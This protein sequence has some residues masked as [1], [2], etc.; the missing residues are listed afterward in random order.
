MLAFTENDM[1]VLEI[2]FENLRQKKKYWSI[3]IFFSVFFR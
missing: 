2:D 1:T 3:G